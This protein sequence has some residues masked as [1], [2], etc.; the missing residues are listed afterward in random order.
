MW[1]NRSSL[2]AVCVG[3]L[4]LARSALA[5]Q[6]TVV[7]DRDTT[8]FEE[9]DLSNG[10]GQHIFTGRTDQPK[11]RRALLRFD[12]AT[13]LP[14]GSTVSAAALRLFCSRTKIKDE[15]VA[16]HRLLADWGEAGSDAPQE[17]GQGAPALIGDAT[18][19]HRFFDTIVWAQ[20]GGDHAVGPSASTI[21][22]GQNQFYTWSSPGM[23]S[24]VQSWLDAP[25]ANFGW[26]VIGDEVG[27]KVTKRFDS[28]ESPDLARRPALTIV[29]SPPSVQ[30]GACCASDGSCTAVLHPGASCAGSYQGASTSC[31]PN[32]CPQP[33][34]ACCLPVASA[35][36]S[37]TSSA[38]CAAQGGN[39]QGT[40][41]SCTPSNPCPVVLTPFVDALPRPPVASPLTGVPGGAAKYQIAIVELDQK[42]HAELPSTRVWGFDDGTA[43][44][45]FPGPTIEAASGQPI[46]LVWKNDLRDASGALRTTH[47]LPVDTCLHGAAT[48]APRTVVHLHG[49]HVP[50]DSDGYPEATFLPGQQVTY[51]YPNDQPAASLWYHDHAIGITRLNVYMGLA[52]F[53]LVRSA[54][55]QALGLPSGEYE[56]P[57]ALQDRTFNSDGTLRY[58]AKWQE[59][60][61]G[62]K[63]LV[64]GKVWPYLDVA[65][66]KYRFR[67]LNG[68]NS[69]TFTLSL[70][71]GA[72]FQQIGSDGGLLQ[73]PVTLQELT[74]TPGERAD[75][76]IDFSAHPTGSQIV[77][78]NSAT[79]PFPESPGVGVV[80][81]VMQFRVL[82]KS[83]HTAPIPSTLSAIAPLSPAQAVISRDFTL[84]KT[85]DPCTGSAWLINGLHWGVISEQPKLGTSEIWRFINTSGA[86]HPMHMHLVFF[87][88]LDRQPFELVGTTIV[89]IGS[90]Q[91]PAANEAGWK[92][93][94]RVEPK[95]M[96]RVIA[97]FEDYVG[98]YPY[99]C[100][101]LEHEDNEMMRQFETVTV[102]GDGALG[103]PQEQCDDGNTT[104][105]DGCD[106]NC[107][108]T[109]CGNG[110]IT[111]GETCDPPASCPTACNDGDPCTLDLLAGSAAAC[112]A[113]CQS[114]PVV[115]CI[116]AD[117]CCPAGCTPANDGDCTTDAGVG[118]S[119]GSGGTA[120]SA[121]GGAGGTGTSGSTGAS[122]SGGGG[123]GSAGGAGEGG[124]AGTGA[125]PAGGASGAGWA[126]SGAIDG[127]A[128][129]GG[130]AAAGTD[131]GE[132]AGTAG[133]DG[134]CDC[135]AA[136]APARPHSLLAL[137]LALVLRRRRGTVRRA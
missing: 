81:N 3:L 19:K 40:A 63:L 15:N 6:V 135:R 127:G 33:N 23:V 95:E 44:G 134:G 12:I 90:P 87:Q 9:G 117:G 69:R 82:D 83:G 34:G 136:G 51:D 100:H 16:L 59:H 42:L 97:R 13:A 7:A 131:G 50:A 11:I 78:Q 70:S 120:G 132:P 118:G 121:N 65:K 115:Q 123:G 126:G 47:Y 109:G 56:V 18:W 66:G 32:P 4:A 57:L 88:V 27:Q 17:E 93:T 25:A 38:S 1:V 52:G 101:M 111:A 43:G 10:A 94:V 41:S 112:T 99:H 35:T 137:M 67:L 14:P 116:D 30:T 26:I 68:S 75:V 80:P 76:V 104:S 36:C 107:T 37:S 106:E 8:L 61:F 39:F 113:I 74:L 31:G 60:F 5:D 92:D 103:K 133:D 45:S 48:P 125:S 102:C 130:A 124:T 24:D 73:A 46:E 58:P 96:V 98:K 84:D 21:V 114:W 64:N 122:G 71:S 91:P 29:Y 110:I 85:T 22:G 129:D 79:A 62:D 49:G 77:L 108:L 105:G 89:P 55:E 72:S 20:L 53:Y 119:A 54:A 86:T 128:I 28:R 2:A